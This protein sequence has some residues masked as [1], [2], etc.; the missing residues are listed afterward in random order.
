M[1]DDKGPATP[2][3]R[4]PV[5]PTQR[6]R[7]RPEPRW[8]FIVH[9]CRL[10]DRRVA[11]LILVA[12]VLARAGIYAVMGAN[13]L[14]DDWTLESLRSEVGTW[15]SVPIGQDLAH[16]RPGAWL[17]F[18]LIHGVIGPHPLVHLGAMTA[19]NIGVT[20]VLY[21]VF[22]RFF[23]RMV[24]LLV[25]AFW[26]ILP[27]HQSM[28]IWSGTSQIAVCALLFL[29]GFLALTYGRWLLGGLGFACSLLCYELPLSLAVAAALLVATPLLPLAP[30]VRPSVAV[31]TKFDR[32][33]VLAMV[34]LV[35]WWSRAH[36]I[37]PV[38]LRIPN[39]V[40]LW[41]AHFGVGLF[42]SLTA[43]NALV[44]GAAAIVAVGVA[45]CLV[46][47][48]AGD[49]A[50]DAGPSLVVAGL[51]V[52]VL[53]LYVAFTLGIGVLGFSDRLYSLSSIGAAMMIG[54][55]VVFLWRRLPRVALMCAVVFVGASLIGQVV[56]LH[57]WSQSGADV[58]AALRY[59][60]QTYPDAASTDFI[61][62]PAPPPNHNGTVGATSPTGGADA[63]FRL[64]YPDAS[65]SLVF[66]N[67]AAEFV[68]GDRG[69]RLIRWSRVLG[70]APTPLHPMSGGRARP[71]GKDP[72]VCQPGSQ[73]DV[74]AVIGGLQ[75][76]RIRSLIDT[77]IRQGNL[78][79]GP[80]Y[81]QYQIQCDSLGSTRVNVPA[82]WTDRFRD[83][84]GV[85]TASPDLAGRVEE[86]PVVGL[87]AAQFSGQRPLLA[88]LLAA[89]AQGSL[90][91][92]TR[93]PRRGRPVAE[94][95]TPQPPIRYADGSYT[96]MAQM[97]VGCDGDRRAWLLV[98]ALP[99]DGSGDNNVN[100]IGQA[101]T[102]GD[103]EALGH[104]LETMQV[105]F[106]RLT[107]P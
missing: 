31:L 34:G 40:T 68:A 18:T 29:L 91:N 99:D 44:T 42:G 36:A 20:L 43:P 89:N 56:S 25:T 14:L 13:F 2:L 52:F 32:G 98:S 21:A 6:E 19:I 90:E 82:A 87:T 4:E 72:Q 48:C 75:N 95:C 11:H 17:T 60:D 10:R 103:A 53:G 47:W 16:A 67:S 61:V 106:S 64:R 63:A 1:A 101:L 84:G 62:G 102:T 27:V 100:L 37:Y 85:V 88:D 9:A 35:T 28:T 107:A 71:S 23:D 77:F 86:E 38:D 92:G 33:K 93:E 50:R 26:V 105:A 55:I 45:A 54:G 79:D 78:S 30:D 69:E 96:G 59:I 15:S 81:H 70:T 58:V 3:G 5:A 49:R 73:V 39:P 12:L 24:A 80:R 76:T 83:Q 94:G 66:A 46:W 8:T 97:Y 104:A 74:P 51:A 22:S 65:G 41:T 7:T 57:A